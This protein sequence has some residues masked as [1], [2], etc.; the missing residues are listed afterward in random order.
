MSVFVLVP[1]PG[2]VSVSIVVLCSHVR[3]TQAPPLFFACLGPT[4][5]INK[6]LRSLPQVCARRPARGR[7]LRRRRSPS[8]GFR[9]SARGSGPRCRSR[10]GPSR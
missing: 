4:S 8:R 2:L 10:S 7:G 5:Q 1:V 3:C 9:S 6:C